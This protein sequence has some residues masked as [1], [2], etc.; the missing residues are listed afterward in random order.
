MLHGDIHIALP[1]QAHRQSALIS[2]RPG[3][4]RPQ[5]Y[6]ASLEQTLT[7]H[8]TES[9]QHS[10]QPEILYQC[11]EHSR[12]VRQRVS[13]LC[14]LGPDDAAQCCLTIFILPLLLP[15]SCLLVQWQGSVCETY[16]PMIGLLQCPPPI[17][18]I[19]NHRVQR[20]EPAKLIA[21]KDSMSFEC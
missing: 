9:A 21:R 4:L 19:K 2:K 20:R 1:I 16:L 13:P 18:A 5:T 3:M 8:H 17:M 15:W 12:R 7:D 14:Y 6:S 11:G 10:S